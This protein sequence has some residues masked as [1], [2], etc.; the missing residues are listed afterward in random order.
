MSA[1]TSGGPSATPTFPPSENQ[2]S[3][4]AFRSPATLAAVR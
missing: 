2:E 1:V 3:A 4:V